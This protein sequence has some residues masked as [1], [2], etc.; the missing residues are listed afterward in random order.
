MFQHVVISLN[1]KVLSE[2]EGP[3]RKEGLGGG[4]HRPTG[5]NQGLPLEA[6]LYLVTK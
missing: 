5:C 2:V 4:R 1:L 3:G 6:T